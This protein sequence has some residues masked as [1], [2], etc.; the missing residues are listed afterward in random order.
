MTRGALMVFDDMTQSKRCQTAQ[1]ERENDHKLSR[2]L[3]LL[4]QYRTN[5]TESKHLAL[6]W[7]QAKCRGVARLLRVSVGA[8][9]CSETPGIRFAANSRHAHLQPVAKMNQALIG[10]RLLATPPF[11][12]PAYLLDSMNNVS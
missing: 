4:V 1:S 8:I 12:N 3:L 11:G 5:F 10:L 2:I 6:W 9:V 7:S